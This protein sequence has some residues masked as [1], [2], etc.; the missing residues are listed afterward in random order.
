MGANGYR[1]SPERLFRSWKSMPSGKS[2]WPYVSNSIALNSS[3]PQTSVYSD[4]GRTQDTCQ[5]KCTPDIRCK[6][7]WSLSAQ[8]AHDSMRPIEEVS[9]QKP[10]HWRLQHDSR[11]NSDRRK[12]CDRVCSS[13]FMSP[14]SLR[15]A[16]C[17]FPLLPL[18]ILE[19]LACRYV[20]ISHSVH[21]LQFGAASDAM[22]T[23]AD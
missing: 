13:A 8:T 22:F 5:A 1:L 16:P 7:L 19:H 17:L 23:V 10:I 21:S 3:L 11:A 18:E 12:R 14:R 2:A 6:G 4:L 20:L 15:P 9:L